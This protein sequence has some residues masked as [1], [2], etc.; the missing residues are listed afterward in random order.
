MRHPYSSQVLEAQVVCLSARVVGDG[1]Y[2]TR[3]ANAHERL[4]AVAID[5]AMSRENIVGRLLE[6]TRI[7]FQIGHED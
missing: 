5:D 3:K 1:G 2:R 7:A 4:R 6:L